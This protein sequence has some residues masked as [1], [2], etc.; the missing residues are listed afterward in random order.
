VDRSPPAVVRHHA[1]QQRKVWLALTPLA[2]LYIV[3]YIFIINEE[4]FTGTKVIT[5]HPAAD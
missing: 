2:V 5:M 1:G 4:I 3:G